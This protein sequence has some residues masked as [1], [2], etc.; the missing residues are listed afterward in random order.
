MKKSKYYIT[1][2]EQEMSFGTTYKVELEDHH[3]NYTCVYERSI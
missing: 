2:E 3:G 1:I